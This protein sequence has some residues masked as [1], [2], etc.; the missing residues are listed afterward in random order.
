MA[1]KLDPE[2]RKAFLDAA[3]ALFVEHGV[4]NT[5]TAAISHKAGTAAGTLFLYFPTKQDLIDALVLKIGEEQSQYIN[6]RLDP[7]LSVRDTFYI[8]WHGSI[9]WLLDHLDAYRYIQQVHDSGIITPSVVAQSAHYFGYYY[10]TIQ[11][12]LAEERI[13]S[14]P[15]DLIGGFL[16]QDIVAVMNV[17]MAMEDAAARDEVIQNGFRI[18]WDGIRVAGK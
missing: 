12:G 17:L 10:V 15:I 5:S 3:L 13:K 11:R 16:Y 4:Q 8:I 7:S 6:S 9:H 18:F 1:R 2:K 14:Y